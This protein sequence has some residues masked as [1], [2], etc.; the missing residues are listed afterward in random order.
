[1][2]FTP[3][4]EQRI[5]Y[6]AEIIRDMWPHRMSLAAAK[7]ID[8]VYTRWIRENTTMEYRTVIDRPRG[9]RVVC[10]PTT[11]LRRARSAAKSLPAYEAYI[12]Q[13]VVFSWSRR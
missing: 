5:E 11:S 10:H 9:K 1:M 13:R 8:K 2:T 3:D 7:V 12:E 6:I 4:T